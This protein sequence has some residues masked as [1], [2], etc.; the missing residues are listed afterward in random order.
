[1]SSRLFKRNMFSRVAQGVTIDLYECIEMTSEYVKLYENKVKE[2][3]FFFV[4]RGT[5]L[6]HEY[7]EDKAFEIAIEEFLKKEERN[8]N[9]VRW[10]SLC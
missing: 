9:K 3:E 6:I 10:I 8:G 5:F 1:M 4:N 2:G 7:D